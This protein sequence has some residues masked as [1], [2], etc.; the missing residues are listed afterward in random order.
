M[1]FTVEGGVI[2]QITQ[3]SAVELVSGQHINTYDKPTVPIDLES[4]QCYW[5]IIFRTN[6]K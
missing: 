2:P 6:D 4:N 3:I 5:N 1:P